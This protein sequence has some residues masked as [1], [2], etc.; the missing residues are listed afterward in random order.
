VTDADVRRIVRGTGRRPLE[1]VRFVR[2]D[3]VALGARSGLWA[4]LG[5]RR[6]AMALRWKRGRCVFL[7]A[8]DRCAIYEHRPTACRQFPFEVT[9]DDGGA[10]ADASLSRIVECP[11]AWDGRVRERAVT[12]VVHASERENAAYRAHV[13][14][15]NRARVGKR[16][17]AAFLGFL[18]LA[19]RAA[20]PDGRYNGA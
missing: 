19:T 16:T 1:F 17:A 8:D 9:L 10:V 11:H 5:R 14:S 4:S 3:E 13:Q 2:P 12:R 6:A 20:A 18:G 7:G 15:W